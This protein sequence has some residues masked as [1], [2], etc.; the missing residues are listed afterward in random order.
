MYLE[1]KKAHK[2]M[3]EQGH[4]ESLLEKHNLSFSELT[5][6]LDNVS[7]AIACM[8]KLSKLDTILMREQV[9]THSEPNPS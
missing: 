6:T 1:V 2:E 7:L 5:D 3:G 9:N 8:I 4:G